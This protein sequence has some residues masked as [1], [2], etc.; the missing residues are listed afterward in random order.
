MTITITET[1]V[2]WNVLIVKKGKVEVHDLK[3]TEAEA[4]EVVVQYLTGKLPQPE[5]DMERS[6]RG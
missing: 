3:R 2:A 1:L 6:I 5:T 4:K